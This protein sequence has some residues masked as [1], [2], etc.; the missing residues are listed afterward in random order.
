MLV[1]LMLV[2]RGCFCCNNVMYVFIIILIVSVVEFKIVFLL[3]YS[4]LC[5][6]YLFLCVLI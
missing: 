3:I 2:E 5:V 6:Y 4:D 1:E